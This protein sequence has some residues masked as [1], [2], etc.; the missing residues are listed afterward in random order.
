MHKSSG[1]YVFSIVFISNI[2]LHMH[3]HFLGEAHKIKWAAW[4]NWIQMAQ[5]HSS[6]TQ[7]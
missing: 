2:F 3:V 6:K 7:K 1:Q 5:I 4:T